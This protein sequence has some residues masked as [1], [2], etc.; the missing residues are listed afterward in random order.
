MLEWFIMYR[1]TQRFM[2]LDGVDHTTGHALLSTFDITLDS[3]R[4]KPPFQHTI[5]DKQVLNLSFE[6]A[7][8]I[9][10]IGCKIHIMVP[11]EEPFQ[12]LMEEEFWFNVIADG[13]YSIINAVNWW[14]CD[15]CIA[16]DGTEFVGEQCHFDLLKIASTG[17]RLK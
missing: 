14:I 4:P 17:S 9:R 8:A 1:S 11:D 16:P 15:T 13:E 3:E 6:G 2:I 7:E 10:E 12:R 5:S